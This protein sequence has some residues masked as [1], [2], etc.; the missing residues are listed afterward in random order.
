[1]SPPGAIHPGAFTTRLARMTPEAQAVVLDW[2]RWHA[3]LR[4]C[5]GL[6][7]L[8]GYEPSDT[9]KANALALESDRTRAEPALFTCNQ[10][11]GQ[12]CE[13]CDDGVVT[14]NGWSF[15]MW[16]YWSHGGRTALPRSRRLGS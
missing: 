7:E 5:A 1:M 12:G 4:R 16:S 13:G 2:Q 6:D 8:V 3:D 14:E 10:C 11:D 15:E 9:A